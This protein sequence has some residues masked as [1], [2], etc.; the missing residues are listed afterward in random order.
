MRNIKI[1]GA[2]LLALMMNLSVG[3]CSP[4]LNIISGEVITENFQKE[5]METVVQILSTKTGIDIQLSSDLYN[6]KVTANF[7]NEKLESA[8]KRLGVNWIE[9]HG[10]LYLGPKN[11]NLEVKIKTFTVKDAS[12]IAHEL[13]P[14]YSSISTDGSSVIHIDT[15]TVTIKA[16]STDL[17]KIETM[18]KSKD[19][20]L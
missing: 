2:C 18:L 17:E 11:Q 6:S 4:S 19:L 9:D 8:I 10:S 3:F 20:L 14:F 1:I 12:K 13:M 5:N 15:N 16:L 7:K